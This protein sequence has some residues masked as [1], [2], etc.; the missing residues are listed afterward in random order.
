MAAWLWK[1]LLAGPAGAVF[2]VG[3]DE[4]LPLREVAERV[5]RITGSRAGV[6]VLGQPRPGEPAERYV[7]DV[8]L[9]RSTLDLPEPLGFDDAVA[10]TARWLR[11]ASNAPVTA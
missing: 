4:A 10:C 9:I 2:N 7:P 1:T 11:H 5:G 6:E 8:R 3:G